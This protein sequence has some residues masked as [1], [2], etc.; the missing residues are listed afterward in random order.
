M[1]QGKSNPDYLPSQIGLGNTYRKLDKYQAAIDAYNSALSINS[2][3]DEAWYNKGLAEE[4]L[5]RYQ[6]AYDSYDQARVIDPL[7]QQYRDAQ[8]RV[9]DKM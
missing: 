4:A 7:K 5:E 9:R 8:K 3:S 2:Q 1:I 6:D